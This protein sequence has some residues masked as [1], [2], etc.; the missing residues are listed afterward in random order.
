MPFKH[1]Q[2]VEVRL[3]PSSGSQTAQEQMGMMRLRVVGHDVDVYLPAS[4]LPA[5]RIQ[6]VGF[7][8]ALHA[9]QVMTVR[10]VECDHVSGH[11]IVSRRLFQLGNP[12]RDEVPSWAGDLAKRMRVTNVHGDFAFGEVMPGVE[13]VVRLSTVKDH[14]AKDEVLV[15]DYLIGYAAPDFANYTV[16]LDVARYL[17]DLDKGRAAA[18]ASQPPAARM[19]EGEEVAP[20]LPFQTV[21]VV[22]DNPNYLAALLE[23]LT[24]DG[25]KVLAAGGN[26][27]AVGRFLGPDAPSEDV[28]RI[29]V[30]LIDMTLGNGGEGSDGLHLAR[31]IREA[32]PETHV[33][34]MSG[35]SDIYRKLKQ[36]DD[37]GFTVHGVLC[38]PFFSRQLRKEL[39]RVAAGVPGRPSSFVGRPTDSRAAA[40]AARRESVGADRMADRLKAF[41]KAVGADGATL[42]SIHRVTLV[43]EAL[44]GEKPLWDYRAGYTSAFWRHKLGRSPVRDVA[45]DGATFNDGDAKAD[46]RRPVN[47]W[48]LRAYDYEACLGVPLES[49]DDKAYCLFAFRRTPGAFGPQHVEA[50]AAYAGVVTALLERDRL[51]QILESQTRYVTSGVAL[52]SL[53]HEL[54]NSLSAALLR[55][56]TLKSVAAEGMG[57]EELLRRAEAILESV[58]DSVEMCDNVME[59]ATPGEPGR[60]RVR[61]A[62][63]KAARMAYHV[64]ERHKARVVLGDVEEG[65]WVEAPPLALEQ[66][67]LNLILNAAE[68]GESF[69]K[70]SGRVEISAGFLDEKKRQARLVVRDNGPGIHYCWWEKIFE[71]GFSTKG[72]T[73]SGLGLHVCRSIVRSLKGEIALLT[74]DLWAGTAF[75][76]TLPLVEGA[77]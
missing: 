8:R 57:G 50:A 53:A 76:V 75:A 58:S 49:R 14:L 56:E 17:A 20:R 12:W 29:D 54:R 36:G 3:I 10:V 68:Q 31:R 70:R 32:R 67:L 61:E 28:Q 4:E 39:T 27:E 37:L 44:A 65:L 46:H 1:G 35:D 48:L 24:N 64:A 72:P 22:D 63:E 47:R 7:E 52:G 11:C 23:I 19:K 77:P 38:K 5:D 2:D 71:A 25:V 16:V 66:V 51:L 6:R 15:G 9:G 33:V 26:E 59:M 74:S 55:A 69:G 42:F 34:L 73:G 18:P 41:A 13:G 62:I 43:T 45:V 60:R 21:L 40:A 30:A